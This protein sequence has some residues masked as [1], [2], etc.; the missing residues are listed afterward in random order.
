MTSTSPIKEILFFL[1]EINDIVNDTKEYVDTCPLKIVSSILSA[2]PE[3]FKPSISFH[4]NKQPTISLI[5][6]EG[7]QGISSFL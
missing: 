2:L 6:I 3:S 4:S 7:N 5:M 1:R